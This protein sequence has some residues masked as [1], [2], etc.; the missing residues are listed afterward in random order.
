MPSPVDYSRLVKRSLAEHPMADEQHRIAAIHAKRAQAPWPPP[1]G[2]RFVRLYG[3]PDDGKMVIPAGQYGVPTPAIGLN[4]HI[5]Y[6]KGRY[7]WGLW[8]DG[9]AYGEYV[10]DHDEHLV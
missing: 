9:V 10:E 6:S 7:E 3:G 1:T 5:Y 4:G 2:P 8:N